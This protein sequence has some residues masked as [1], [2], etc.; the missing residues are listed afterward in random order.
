MKARLGWLVAVIGA[1]AVALSA[2]AQGSAKLAVGPDSGGYLCPDGRQ[3]YVK[4]CYDASPNANCGVVLMHLPQQRGY[5]QERTQTRTEI[6]ASVA[7]CKVYPLDFKDGVVSLVVP[8]NVTQAQAQAP[9]SAPAGSTVVVPG[10][11]GKPIALARLPAA[12]DKTIVYYVDENMRKPLAQPDTVGIWGLWVYPEGPKEFP[13]MTAAWVEY[14]INCKAGTWELGA[15]IR[16]D[17]QAKTLGASSVGLKGSITKGTILEVV[18][19]IACQTR[20]APDGTRLTTTVAAINDAMTPAAPAPAAKSPAPA[21]LKLVRLS[22]KGVQPIARYVLLDS[23]SPSPSVPNAIEIL[24]LMI[25]SDAEK[26]TA[27]MRGAWVGYAVTCTPRA[28]RLVME[29]PVDDKGASGTVQV[30][31]RALPIVSGTEVE[32]IANI[33]CGAT[34]PTGSRLTSVAAAITD[35]AKKPTATPRGAIKLA[36]PVKA[37][38]RPPESEAEKTFLQAIKTNR[39]QAAINATILPPGEKPVRIAELTDEQGM[40]ALH[41]AV[42]NRNLAGLGWMLDK[43]P[44][45]NWADKKG[46]TPLKIALD[47]KHTD[48]MRMLL[49]R[50]ADPNLVWPFHP[51]DLKGFRTTRELVDFMIAAGVPASK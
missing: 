49:D 9:A 34:P 11:G 24:S 26:E 12:T 38:I 13:G 51:D 8:T 22:P 27:A 37:P 1:G 32:Q 31:D 47:N 20:K 2:A 4:S 44:E 3:L 41:W 10:T 36:V 46:S 39:M 21:S 17:R 15:M 16:L 14:A 7:V 18:G 43:K 23:A 45:L 19:G 5:Q 6:T 28:L 30:F 25:F 40:T 35:A 50:G 29:M 42:A 48:A 33:A